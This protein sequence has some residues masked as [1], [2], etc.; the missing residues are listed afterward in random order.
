MYK[1]CNFN[2]IAYRTHILVFT[3]ACQILKHIALN[4]KLVYFIIHLLSLDE[5]CLSIAVL[6]PKHLNEYAPRT[7]ASE[8]ILLTHSIIILL[9]DDIVPIHKYLSSQMVSTDYFL[10][11]VRFAT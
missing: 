9:L 10:P 3:L 11:T 2:V 7:F 6:P 1:T 5:Q 8:N 4:R